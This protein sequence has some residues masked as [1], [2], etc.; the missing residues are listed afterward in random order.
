MEK[1]KGLFFVCGGARSGKSEFAEEL[2]ASFGPRVL[3]IATAQ[4][5]DS[6]M[7]RRI[8]LHQ[9][10]RPKEWD[11]VEEPLYVGKVIDNLNIEYDA[12]LFDCLTVYLN[13][14]YFSEESQARDAEGKQSYI[15]DNMKKLAVTCSKA[16]C[17]VIAVS[18]EVGMG[19]VPEYPIGR[20]YRDLA[21]WG[22]QFFAR[23]ACEAYFVVM[24]IPV[25]L[26][27]LN[28]M[29]YRKVAHR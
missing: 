12:V 23:E 11:T 29:C 13:N 22:N 18:N 8:T 6:E 19:I 14:L 9:K 1:D 20:E 3:Y 5:F 16:H 25:E 26:K 2:A 17:P 7:E 10:R 21:G 28:K 27:S 24:G 15:L 4:S